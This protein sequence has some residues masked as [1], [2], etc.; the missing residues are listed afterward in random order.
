ML[1]MIQF[2]Y[3]LKVKTFSCFDAFWYRTQPPVSHGSRSDLSQTL[4]LYSPVSKTKEVLYSLDFFKPEGKLSIQDLPWN[5]LRKVIRKTTSNT[6]S[7]L[8]I[9]PFT[10]IFKIPAQSFSAALYS[11]S[12]GL[13]VSPFNGKMWTRLTFLSLSLS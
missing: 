4:P 11:Q 2:I 13:S 10:I 6:C 7:H 9:H 5:H 3:C 8:F 12:R 1:Y